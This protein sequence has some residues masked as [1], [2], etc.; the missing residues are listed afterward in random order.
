M[1]FY[2]A[3][4]F[5]ILYTCGRY[6]ICGVRVFSQKYGLIISAF[7]LIFIA[8]FRFDV[9][10]DYHGYFHA[11]Y[12][13]LNIWVVRN[14]E[15]IP[16]LIY[17]IADYLSSP[18]FV[19]IAFGVPTYILFFKTFHDLSV[20][21]YESFI[22]FFSMFYLGTM[23]TIRQY[24]ALAVTFYGFRFVKQKKF[25]RYFICC[26]VAFLCHK[27]AIIAVFIYPIYYAN[28]YLVFLGAISLILLKNILFSLSSLFHLYSYYLNQDLSGG[29]LIRF[30]YIIVLLAQIVFLHIYKTK[31][32]K[33]YLNLLSVGAVL[34]FIFGSSMGVRLALY[35]NVFLCLS[36]PALFGTKKI[37]YRSISVFCFLGYFALLLWYGENDPMKTVY[38]PYQLY[39][40]ADFNNFRLE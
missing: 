24:L 19:F 27:S 8:V 20:N 33:Q 35:F 37:H 18:L 2:F 14:F 40:F 5:F 11:I 17:Y 34:P 6:N 12:P 16:K 29:K 7:L 9:G 39:F 30:F 3:I 31:E 13:K 10:F 22:I 25:L 23:D 36:W 38:T 21:E 28:T 26:V 32:H 1:F 15:P 4:V